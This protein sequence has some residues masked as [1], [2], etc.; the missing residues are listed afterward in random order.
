MTL[1]CWVKPSAEFI[2]R[3]DHDMLKNR[4][5][6]T[7]RSL[8]IFQMKTLVKRTSLE[9]PRHR[10][11]NIENYPEMTER[12]MPKAKDVSW[13]RVLTLNL[14]KIN[15][16]KYTKNGNLLQTTLKYKRRMSYDDI[17]GWIGGRKQKIGSG[18]GEARTRD[19]LRV[20]QTW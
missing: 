15:K 14:N 10:E 20:K 8:F 2:T 1:L 4:W 12:V 19:L 16:M 9:Q 18:F 7:A 17:F 13:L 11:I 6:W 3:Q 5:M